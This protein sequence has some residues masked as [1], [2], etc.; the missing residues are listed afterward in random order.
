MLSYWSLAEFA[1]EHPTSATLVNSVMSALAR[2][3]YVQFMYHWRLHRHVC[4]NYSPY[5]PS[6]EVAPGNGQV[7]TEC[8]GWQ[9]YNWGAL[10]G[11]PALLELQAKANEATAF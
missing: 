1:I 7:N 2:Q 11:V 9:F 6:S 5:D 4:E 10:N 8:T 3:K